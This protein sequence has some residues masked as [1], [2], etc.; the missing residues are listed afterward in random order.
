MNMPLRCQRCKAYINPYFKIDPSSK[1][2]VCNICGVKFGIPE[3]TD[4]ENM[5][6]SEVA[7]EGVIDFEVTDKFYM[8]KRVDYV[9]VIIAIEMT[10]PMLETGLFGSI[11]QSVRSALEGMDF[12]SN[13]RVGIIYYN[14]EG[15]TFI[16][17]R[18]KKEPQEGEETTEETEDCPI[19]FKVNTKVG[20]F[21]C[22]LSDE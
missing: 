12:E 6:R 19:E 15:V 2:A 21:C 18:P 4:K 10:L 3:T 8:R 16:K 1:S 14:D 17:A 5:N 9:K 22:P 13:V 11:T 20:T 7:I